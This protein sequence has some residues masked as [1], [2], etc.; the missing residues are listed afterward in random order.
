M[1]REK[2]TTCERDGVVVVRPYSGERLCR[3]C[4]LQNFERRVQRTITRY[5]MLKEDDRI[6]VA[7]SGGKDSLT[8]LRVLVKIERRFP[9]ASVV[10]VTVD[11]GIPGYREEALENARRA[12]EELGVEQVVITFEEAFGFTVSEA[13]EN[14]Y[15]GELG[16]GECT[17]CGVLRRKAIEL[18][19]MRAG[20]TVIATAHTLDDIVQ[21]YVM[22]ALRGDL[23]HPPIG[24]RRDGTGALP[25]VAPLRLTPEREVILYAYYTGIPM[26]QVECP[27]ASGS[28]RSLIR[29]FL[30]EFEERYPGS[31]YAALTSLENLLNRSRGSDFERGTCRLCGL[32][33]GH[34]LCRSCEIVS[35][36]VNLKAERLR[37]VPAVL[38]TAFT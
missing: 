27:Y 12:C 21:T 23:N 17:V 1:N 16:L 31:L 8:L 11:E 30:N 9:K 13:V 2:C 7:L 28:Q 3:S 24:L 5:D 33:S 15:A 37:R 29:S 22:N 14:G 10:A 32:P 18:G 38:Q 26:Q 34:D 36:I 25:R 19:A 20:A 4:F 6:A 35:S